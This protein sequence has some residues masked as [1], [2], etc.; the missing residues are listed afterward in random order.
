MARV[1]SGH[2]GSG[3]TVDE[4]FDCVVAK[5]VNWDSILQRGNTVFDRMVAAARARPWT[6]S[7]NAMTAIS[8]DLRKLNA[9][10]QDPR[11]IAVSVAIG[12]SRHAITYY[13]GNHLIWTLVP[14]FTAAVEAERREDA[15]IEVTKLG[16][17]LA[18]YRADHAKYPTTLLDLVPEYV[19]EVPPD[20]FTGHPFV[21][22]K[23]DGGYLLYSLGANGID[24]GGRG[25]DDDDKKTD[26]YEGGDDVSLEVSS[27]KRAASP[28]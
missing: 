19:K 13:F 5:S 26:E 24:E 27:E 15:H 23:A 6:E 11:S 16:Y 22:R 4:V 25:Y 7:K 10:R 21:Y 1:V 3:N 8:T 20:P 17:L 9:K 18:A 12:G 14:A 2:G 28:K